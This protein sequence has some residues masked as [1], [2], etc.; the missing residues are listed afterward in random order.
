VEVLVVDAGRGRRTSTATLTTVKTHSSSSEV[1]PPSAARSAKK[2]S[3]KAIAVVNRIPA[4]GVRRRGCTLPRK[5]GRTRCFD[6]PYSSRLAMS[7]LISAEFATAN[8]V[9][10]AKIPTGKS[11]APAADDLQQR[12]V[13]LAEV[14]GVTRATDEIDTRM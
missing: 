7:M 9:M 3:P 6:M 11:G 4:Q 13:A 5:R 8:I 10:K 2:M 14:L 1:V 12:R